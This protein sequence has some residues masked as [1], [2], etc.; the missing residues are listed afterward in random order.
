M[1][2]V[3]GIEMSERRRRPETP[4]R[5]PCLNL[6]RSSPWPFLVL[7]SSQKGDSYEHLELLS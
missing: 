6:V 5:P 3:I 4:T 7:F 2:L 1:E